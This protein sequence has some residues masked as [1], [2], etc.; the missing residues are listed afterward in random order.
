MKALVKAAPEEGL[1]LR[2]EP[3]PEIGPDDIL[4]KVAK[5]G[6]CGTDHPEIW[7]RSIGVPP[8]RIAK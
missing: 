3:V 2:E 7:N 4:I 1:V 6:I 8:L 5:T